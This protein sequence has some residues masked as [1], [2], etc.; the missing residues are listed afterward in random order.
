MVKNLPALQETL[1][2]FLGQKVCWGR[3]RLPTPVFL[4]F[5]CGSAGKESTC[6]EGDLGLIPVLGRSPGERKGYPLQYSCLENSTDCIDRAVTESDKTEP[7]SLSYR[8]LY[9][10]TY[11]RN[12]VKDTERQSEKQIHIIKYMY[13][14]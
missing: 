2:R 13:I 4:G 5:P 12:S 8:K 6:N 1:V 11:N 3:D 9:A 7:L 14:E 10:L